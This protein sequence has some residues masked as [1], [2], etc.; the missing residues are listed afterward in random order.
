MSILSGRASQGGSLLVEG[1]CAMLNFLL[2]DVILR[3]MGAEE[4]SASWHLEK[5][6]VN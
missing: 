3:I 6:S 1:S 2:P 5:A 4:V